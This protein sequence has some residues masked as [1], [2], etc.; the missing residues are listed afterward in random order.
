MRLLLFL[1]LSFFTRR[2]RAI[3]H[4]NRIRGTCLTVRYKKCPSDKCPSQPA[5][6]VETSMWSRAFQR[7]SLLGVKCLITKRRK[8]ER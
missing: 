5:P 8:K 4:K 1:L 6:V 2:R 3:A 7:M